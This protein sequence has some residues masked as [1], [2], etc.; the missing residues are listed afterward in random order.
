M[1]QTT[2]GW[3]TAAPYQA[4]PHHTTPAPSSF[5]LPKRT[6]TAAEVEEEPAAADDNVLPEHL[7]SAGVGQQNELRLITQC[8]LKFMSSR[9]DYPHATFNVA[10]SSGCE[11]QDGYGQGKVLVLLG[12]WTARTQ[13]NQGR[14]KRRQERL[15]KWQNEMSGRGGVESGEGRGERCGVLGRATK[16]NLF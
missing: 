3:A 11:R 13:R 6:T 10:L 14:E 4:I 8:K 1:C 12:N 5:H 15:A 7:A 16:K 2:A 9:L